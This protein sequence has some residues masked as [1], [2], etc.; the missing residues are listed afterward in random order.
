VPV[1]GRM[2]TEEEI[3]YYRHGGLLPYVYRELM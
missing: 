1:I 2:D 3:A